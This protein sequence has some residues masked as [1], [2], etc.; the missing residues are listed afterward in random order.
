MYKLYLYLEERKRTLNIKLLVIGNTIVAFGWFHAIHIKSLKEERRQVW[1]ITILCLFFRH[2]SSSKG[3]WHSN[4]GQLIPICKSEKKNLFPAPKVS[5]PPLQISESTDSTSTEKTK[6][7]HPTLIIYLS[8]SRQSASCYGNAGVRDTAKNT[9]H[10]QIL[11]S[12]RVIHHER[13][14]L[15]VT[16]QHESIIK[17]RNIWVCNLAT[18]PSH[19]TWR[20]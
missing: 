17:G 11:M 7:A 8:Y 16:G 5:E 2:T 15:K 13:Y 14:K 1:H 9:Q 4:V 20:S 3:F 10:K 19:C 12:L 18:L 6:L